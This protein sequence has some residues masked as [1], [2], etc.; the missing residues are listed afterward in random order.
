MRTIIATACNSG[1]YFRLA[2]M[3]IASIHK[4]SYDIV[5]EIKVLDLGLTNDEINTL[6]S[7][8]KVNVIAFDSSI[9]NKFFREYWD[10][11][12]FGWKVYF[13][14]SLSRIYRNNN[15]VWVDAGVCFINNFQEVIDLINIDHIFATSIGKFTVANECIK[16]MNCTNIELI[17]SGLQA[18]FI[19]WRAGGGKQYIIDEWYRYSTY[20][21]CLLD[22]GN[23]DH[24]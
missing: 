15:L 2:N 5:D 1:K 24:R 8:D 4:H 19:G 21:E 20:P 22:Y 12:K 9:T 3:L 14:Y 16:K 23:R 7:Y 11:K 10:L 17:K 18:G 6:I 13:I